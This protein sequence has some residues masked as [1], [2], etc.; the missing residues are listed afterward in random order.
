MAGLITC[1]WQAFPDFTNMEIIKAVIKSSTI[2]NAPDDRIGYGIPNFHTAFDDLNQQQLLRNIN[3]VLGNNHIKIFPNPFVNNFNIIIKP[4]YTA[5]ATFHLYDAF[6]RLYLT[7]QA[8]LQEGQTQL[9]QFE[10]F[11]PLQKGIYTLKFND[12]QSKQSFKL[13]AQ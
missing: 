13:V 5:N 7:K 9:I 11:Q 10:N 8:P 4:L 2:Y 1:L 3:A 6:G 12:G